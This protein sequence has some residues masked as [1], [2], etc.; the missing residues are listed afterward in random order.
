MDQSEDAGEKNGCDNGERPNGEDICEGKD[1]KG[2]DRG[3]KRIGKYDYV[4]GPNGE[5][6][7]EGKYDNGDDRGDDN[8]DDRGDDN[9]DITYTQ[10]KYS[11]GADLWTILIS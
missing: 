9:R 11:L 10:Q 4:E 5:D 7:G 2:E 1:D 6:L 3:E 8:V